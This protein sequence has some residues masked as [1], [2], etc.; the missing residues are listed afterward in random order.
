MFRCTKLHGNL[1]PI[2]EE[3]FLSKP[4]P[5]GSAKGEVR[6]SPKDCRIPP[7]RTMNMCTELLRYFSRD[8]SGGLTDVAIPNRNS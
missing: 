3:T 5:H 8:Q 2:V 4:Q 1:N 7:L 6:G